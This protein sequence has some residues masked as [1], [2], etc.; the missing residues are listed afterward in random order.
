MPTGQPTPARQSKGRQVPGEEYLTR[1]RGSPHWQIGFRIERHRV[2]ESSGTEDRLAAAELAH[3]RWSEVW[4]QVKLGEAPRRQL[5]LYDAFERYYAEVACKTAYGRR[6]Q[7]YDMA[8]LRAAIGGSVLLSQLDDQLVND[9][10]QRM[11]TRKPTR[12]RPAELSPATVNRY[13]TTLHCVCRR[14]RDLW[15]MEVGPWQRARH[16]LAEPDGRETFLSHDEARALLAAACG[17]LRPILM[18]DLMTGM[19]RGNVLGLLWEQISLDLAR[20]VLRQKGDRRLAV[21]LPPPALELLA[22]IEPDPAKRRGPVFRFGNPAVPCACPHC[23]NRRFAG[24]PVRSIKRA[25]ATAVRGAGLDA[26]PAGRLRFH[27]LR[28]TVASWWLAESGDLK[29]VQ[30]G[31]GHK[32]IASTARYAHLVTGRK[33]A[34]IGA[35]AERLIAAPASPAAKERNRA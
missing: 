14:A 3:Q 24:Q 11:R 31:L 15:G 17:H 1:R 4:R 33:E 25:F 22:S 18:L 26:L 8:V 30:E 21:T 9:A 34:V 28:H 12:G 19:R 7:L 20:A 16:A 35:A 5:T 32:D 27:D 29:V 2:R 10:V 23:L 13:V 6:G